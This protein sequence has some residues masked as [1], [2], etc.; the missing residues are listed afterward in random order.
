MAENHEDQQEA[1]TSLREAV[2]DLQQNHDEE[3]R[4]ETVQLPYEVQKKTIVFGG[5]PAFIS[6]MQN[7][8]K[9]SVR[10]IDTNKGFDTAVI[11]E[12]DMIWLQTNSMSH[13][14]YYRI[15]NV[16]RGSDVALQ[17]FTLAG[18]RSCAVQLALLDQKN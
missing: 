7:L 16:V 13:S 10:F 1:L 8:L 17:Y 18:T 14:A 4:N 2:F 12:A 6:G 5:H 11:E 15:M 9:G 3:E